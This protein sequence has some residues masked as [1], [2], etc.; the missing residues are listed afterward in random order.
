MLVFVIYGSGTLGYMCCV[1]SE[2]SVQYSVSALIGRQSELVILATLGH[3]HPASMH[4]DCA[5]RG[6]V[7]DLSWIRNEIIEIFTRKE[8]EEN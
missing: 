3:L 7:P 8:E 2:Y 5:E 4:A 1:R 6:S